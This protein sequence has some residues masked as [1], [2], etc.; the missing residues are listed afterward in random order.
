MEQD[1]SFYLG[2][3]VNKFIRGS[4]YSSDSTQ[5]APGLSPEHMFATSSGRIYSLL[6]ADDELSIDLT[7]LQR[8]MAHYLS[9]QD[10]YNFSR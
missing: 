6:N 7:E 2:E 3:M 10:D 8:N 9:N 1:G 4:I 5:W